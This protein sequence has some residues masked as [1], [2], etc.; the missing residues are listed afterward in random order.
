M[1]RKS[2]RELDR[3]ID[4]LHA[5]AGLDDGEPLVVSIGRADDQRDAP[6]PPDF[7]LHCWRAEGEWHSE[8]VW[9]SERV[10]VDAGGT[11]G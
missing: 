1:T 5:P 3:A 8:G 6:A 11:D 9:H 7:V 2:E 4:E 10:T